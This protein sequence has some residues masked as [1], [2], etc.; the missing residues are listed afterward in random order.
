ARVSPRGGLSLGRA[1]PVVV[2]RCRAGVTVRAMTN[3]SCLFETDEDVFDF[4]VQLERRHAQLAT[5]A[6]AFVTAEGRLLVNAAAAVD[7]QHARSDPPRQPERP[8]DIAGPDR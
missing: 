3:P 1:G 8:A 5:D 2:R 6:G 7:A 4:R